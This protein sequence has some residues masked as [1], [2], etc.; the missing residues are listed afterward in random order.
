MLICIPSIMAASFV[1]GVV[2]MQYVVLCPLSFTF[3]FRA[4]QGAEEYPT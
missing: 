1:Y 3:T 2:V 4:R